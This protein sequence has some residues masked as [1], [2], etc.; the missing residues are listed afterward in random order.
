MPPYQPAAPSGE[1]ISSSSVT[2]LP[3]SATTSETGWNV[4]SGRGSVC[5]ATSVPSTTT[6]RGT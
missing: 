3:S 2:L 5:R 4:T 1:T 6:P